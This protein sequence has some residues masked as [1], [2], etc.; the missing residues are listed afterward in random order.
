[1]WV[2]NEYDMDREECVRKWEKSFSRKDEAVYIN[3]Q[4]TPVGKGGQ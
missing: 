2:Q 4:G 1:M 3:T